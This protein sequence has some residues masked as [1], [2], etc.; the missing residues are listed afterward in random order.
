MRLCIGQDAAVTTVVLELLDEGITWATEV[1][2]PIPNQQGQ[3]L[4]HSA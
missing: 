3:I 1:D 2:D 4:A